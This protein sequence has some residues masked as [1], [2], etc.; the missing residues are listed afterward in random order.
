M[1]RQ[2]DEGEQVDWGSRKKVR[3]LQGDTCNTA[4]NR[5]DVAKDGLAGLRMWTRIAEERG[6]S[7]FHVME[8]MN[9]FEMKLLDDS[10]VL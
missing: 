3:R 8:K 6:E 5:A 10:C 2:S 7:T 4:A 1:G 9:I